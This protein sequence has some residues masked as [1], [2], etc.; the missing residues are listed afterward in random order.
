MGFI[1]PDNVVIMPYNASVLSGKFDFS[2]RTRLLSLVS[3]L[4]QASALGHPGVSQSGTQT[5][6]FV[7]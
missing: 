2:D 1:L 6:S 5:I 4:F 3:M 7:F